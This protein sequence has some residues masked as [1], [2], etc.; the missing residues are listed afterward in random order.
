MPT[1][2][3]TAAIRFYQV[4]IS[5]TLPTTCRFEPSCSAYALE[6]IRTHGALR[7]GWLTARR[8]LSCRPF[9]RCGF[10]PVPPPM[11]QR[12]PTPVAQDFAMSTTT[13]DEAS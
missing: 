13:K 3:L 5:P 1:R 9:G 6:A 7:G 10:D 4:A 12:P 8:L 2:I 11:S